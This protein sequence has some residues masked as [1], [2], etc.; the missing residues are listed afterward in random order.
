MVSTRTQL[1]GSKKSSSSSTKKASRTKKRGSSTSSTSKK[2]AKRAKVVEVHPPASESEPEDPE[3]LSDTEQE[4]EEL[5]VASGEATGEPESM[6]DKIKGVI[7]GKLWRVCKF[8][9]GKKVRDKVAAKCY[10]LIG[11]T[12]G[13]AEWVETWGKTVNKALNNVRGYACTEIKKKMFD[14]WEEHGTVPSLDEF[15]ACLTRR[16]DPN[17]QDELALFA[18]WWDQILDGACANKFD[19]CEDHRLYLKISTAAPYP[20]QG[21]PNRAEDLYMNPSTEAFALIVLENYLAQWVGQFEWKK[22]HKKKKIPAYKKPVNRTADDPNFPETKWTNP[23]AGQQTYCGWDK[24]ALKQ[25]EEYKNLNKT[26]RMTPESDA[27]EEATLAKL[28]VDYKVT[29]DAPQPRGRTTKKRDEV[30]DLDTT[31]F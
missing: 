2:A 11:L 3:E 25:F 4:E 27:L 28:K 5:M 19:W 7:Q 22:L 13:Q 6:A 31:D 29:G 14:Y 15:R 26:A 10:E 16:I 1:D 20:S 18:F 23:H 17:N 30:E 21:R 9:M 24:E 8:I 12:E